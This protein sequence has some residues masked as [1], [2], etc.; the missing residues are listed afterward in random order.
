[1]VTDLMTEAIL[2]TPG[3]L[4][5]YAASLDPDDAA[6]LVEH[7]KAEADRHW[8]IN[9]NRS[10]ELAELIVRVGQARRDERVTALGTMARG[11]A[12]KFLGQLEE[13]WETLEEA[14]RRF[15]AIGDEVGWGRTRIGR[16]LLCVELNR[17]PEAL[18]DAQAARAI[19]ERHG[20]RER[21]LRVDHNMGIAYEILGEYQR[22]LALYRSALEIAE[23]L[24]EA[25][26]F[27]MGL[28]A[29]DI[30]TAE[31]ALGHVRAAAESFERA[32]AACARRGET[33]GV[34]LA[35]LN[36]AELATAQGQY[37]RALK[38]L[39]HAHD[40][41]AEEHLPLDAA[42]ASHYMAEC[43]LMLNRL[44]EARDMAR[45]VVAEYRGFGA[46][47]Q[48]GRALLLLAAAEAGLGALGAAQEALAEAEAVFTA[49]D[50]RPLLASAWLRYGEVALAAGDA[51][52]AR[53]L[54]DAALHEYAAEGL[55]AERAQALLL[56]GRANLALDETAAATTDGTGVLQIARQCNLPAL[57]YAGHLLLG[58]AAEARGAYARAARRYAAAVATIDRVQ[59]GLT[60]TLRPG[61]L[62]NRTEAWHRLI[63]LCLRHGD[64]TGAFAALERVKSQAL[65]GYLANRE[66]FRWHGRDGETQTL[67][68]E[69]NELR[70]EHHWFYRLAHER[71]DS[72]HE[73]PGALSP[74]EA[75][76]ELA[77]RERRIRAITERLYLLTAQ[78]GAGP[79]VPP[80]EAIRGSLAEDELLLAFYTDGATQWAFTVDR[81][82]LA[83][84][85]LPVAPGDVDRLLA[86][87]QANIDFALHT[88]PDAPAARNLALVARR[89]LQRLHAALIAPLA[90]RLAGRSRLIV[91]PY[92]ALHYLPFH[93]LHDGAGYLVEQYEVATLPAAGLRTRAA[94]AR[95]PGALALAHSWGGRLPQTV[96]EAAIVVRSL[97]GTVFAEAEAGR[98]VLG[99]EPRQVLHIA[100]HGEHR[101]DQPDLSYIELADGQLY[102]DDLLQQDMSYELVV[103]SAC[104]TGRANVAAG[105]ELIGLGRG[106]LYAGAGALITSLWRVADGTTA[107][108]M[109][110]L[111]TALAGG[112]AK[113]SALRAAQLAALAD[114]PDAH[115]AFWGA[116]QLV[117]DAGPLSGKVMLCKSR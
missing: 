60:I 90:E 55:P 81:D 111:Y 109:E 18:A 33:R 22:A 6:R 89:L 86:Q 78:E 49:L 25:G 15:R 30:G 114:A 2:T 8:W 70:A 7:L 94:P 42:H 63:G 17:V 66:Q 64:A 71:P 14:G 20:D 37:R 72:D 106:F 61:F 62:E 69:L 68:D 34:A 73:Q 104:E 16:L 58:R 85:R 101:L 38:L 117:G 67:L 29:T 95:R 87:L 98:S 48:A 52:E 4:E 115:P 76:A 80:L 97:G 13:A 100:A 56:R 113:A 24:G 47:H 65:L 96:A 46:M 1:M 3:E 84:H 10:L 44:A 11:D 27:Y 32:R 107:R 26:E 79:V 110:R 50:A 77:A 83:L 45:A 102:T 28:L 39:H 57:R 5:A 51:A 54:A 82:T 21:V 75:R 23:S 59:R 35:E 91:V 112:A 12:L 105:D 9:A 40:L 41:Y 53:R 108:L 19:F 116:F 74:Q 99:Q 93:L 43:Y 31:R 92:G 103:L 36:I 88:G